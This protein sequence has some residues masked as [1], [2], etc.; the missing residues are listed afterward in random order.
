MQKLIL[1]RHG[2]S[3]W[4]KEN[5][6]T[7]WT[8]VGLTEK[9]ITEA[10]KA[11]KLLS[12]AGLTFNIAFTS[13]LK[14][15]IKALWVVMEDMDLMWTPVIRSWR[16]NERHYGGLQGLDKAKTAEKHGAK[17]VHQWRRSYDV[18]PPA[19]ETGNPRHPRNE[20]KYADVAPELL[21]ATECLKDTV[22]RFL[23]FWK[24]AIVPEIEGGKKVMICAH[25]NSLRALVKHLDNISDEDI[26]SLNMGVVFILRKFI[27]YAARLS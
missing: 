11:A 19:L 10:R 26:P 3:V 1:L 17:Q 27:V 25:G 15:A 12:E 8:D 20:L 6:F 18:R 21:P 9:G 13:L 4:N 14:R 7:G 2:E 16:L 24:E 5:K 23:P 22:E